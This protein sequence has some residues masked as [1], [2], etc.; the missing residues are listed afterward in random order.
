MNQKPIPLPVLKSFPN[1]IKS[2]LNQI[3]FTM[4]RLIWNQNII[5][6]QIDLIR[7]RK[8]TSASTN[9]RTHKALRNKTHWKNCTE[10]AYSCPRGC[11]L[12]EIMWRSPLNPFNTVEHYGIGAFKG[13]ITALWC[14]GFKGSTMPRG[15]VGCCSFVRHAC[16][17]YDKLSR[18]NSWIETV[19]NKTV[20]LNFT[21]L[22]ISLNV[23]YVLWNSTPLGFVET[24]CF[25][26]QQNKMAWCLHRVI[27]YYFMGE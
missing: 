4:H 18:G 12:A 1:L 8:D 11:S 19:E 3:V 27:I 9:E 26:F 16:I 23:L 22:G 5:S 17:H 6:F 15:E 10:Q 14:R 21:P 24:K 2:N 25:Y 13:N 7:F 20:L